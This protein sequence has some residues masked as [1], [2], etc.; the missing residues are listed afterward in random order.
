[1]GI[2]TTNLDQSTLI[3]ELI[4]NYNGS[5][6]RVT[7]L[8]LAAVIA[9]MQGPTYATQSELDAD[10]DWPAGSQGYV[11]GD[12]EPA[13]NGR[14]V[15]NGPAG[16]GSWTRVGDLLS[17]GPYAGELSLKAPLASPGF[18]GIPTVPTAAPGTDTTQIASTAFV[19]A[20]LAAL[21]DAAPGALDT[22]NELAAALGDDANFAATMATAL[23][24]K[25][26]LASPALTGTPTAPT[27][28][29]GTNTTQLANTAFVQDVRAQLPSYQRAGVSPD[30]SLTPGIAL[31]IVNTAGQRVGAILDTGEPHLP[32]GPTLD[33]DLASARLAPDGTVLDATTKTG[34][35]VFGPHRFGLAFEFQ[36]RSAT[37][38]ALAVVD[39][40]GVDIAHR[41][42]NAWISGGQV[43]LYVRGTATQITNHA[44]D[45]WVHA[46]IRGGLFLMIKVDGTRISTP[47]AGSYPW[48]GHS[49]TIIYSELYGQSLAA[50]NA[51]LTLIN[52]T[53]FSTQHLMFEAGQRTI[54]NYLGHDQE[55]QQVQVLPYDA[56]HNFVPGHETLVGSAGETANSGFAWGL[57]GGDGE[58]DET[59]SLL[60]TCSAV[61]SANASMLVKGST[62]WSDTLHLSPQ[63]VLWQNVEDKFT[64]ARLFWAMQGFRFLA[65]PMIWN[66]G[67]GNYPDSKAAY[68]AWLETLRDDWQNLAD[69]WMALP[70][71]SDLGFTGKVPFITAQTCS[72]A[73]YG[74]AASQVPWAQLQL[75]LDDPT[76]ALCLGPVYDQVYAADGVHLLAAGQEMQGARA[77]VAFNAWLR[78]ELYKPLHVTTAVRTGSA[79]R[80]TI[81]NH[82]GHS[83]TADTATITGLGASHGFSWLDDGDGNSVTV[84]SISIS[85]GG[86]DITLSDV[87]TGSN[88]SIGIGLNGTLL[89][90]A[91]PTSGN[92]CT[93][94]TNAPTPP[95]TR[96]GRAVH[97]FLCIDRIAVTI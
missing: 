44:G 2:R 41:D 22:L 16:S 24:L 94:R 37:G 17:G 14:Y 42:L 76:T 83:L 90:S 11:A 39:A 60:T 19:Q 48:Q 35:L 75:N 25:A 53:A 29:P 6:V 72:G 71:A 5:T 10:L 4:G 82:F 74:L 26:P 15:K 8:W 70:G 9:A 68:L 79:V 30:A 33:A 38:A 62:Q 63:G 49:R 84:S 27:A 43:W 54:G 55:R 81:Y 52:S 91:G 23:G 86:I 36:Q 3:D 69:D 77:A 34:E 40:F 64:R 67:E 85:G 18:S 73:H 1:M 59:Q 20:A 58:L 89:G 92:R 46:E 93:I 57:K 28:A 66:Q 65:G 80:L 97:H 45:P 47:V 7:L 95:T 87:P 56:V 13:N 61:G 21:L 50:A 78:G 12:S 31:D 96:D 88:P 32:G 51:S